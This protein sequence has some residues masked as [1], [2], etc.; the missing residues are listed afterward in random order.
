MNIIQTQHNRKLTQREGLA[1]WPVL[2]YCLSVELG[3]I[4]L[5]TTQKQHTHLTGQALKASGT[6]PGIWQEPKNIPWVDM[7]HRC[8]QAQCLLDFGFS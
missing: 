3:V 8:T 1:L 6:K 7:A 5:S 2:F 4:D